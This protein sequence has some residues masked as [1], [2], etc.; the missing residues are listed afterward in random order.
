MQHADYF[1]V[2]VDVPYPVFLYHYI[3][4]STVQ[5]CCLSLT[6]SSPFFLTENAGDLPLH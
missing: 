3:F 4:F 6:M 5:L 2:P 1:V